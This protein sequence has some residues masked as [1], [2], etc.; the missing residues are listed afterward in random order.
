[1]GIGDLGNPAAMVPLRLEDR[2]KI[3]QQLIDEYKVKHGAMDVGVGLV[4]L[5][6]GAAIPA[7]VAAIAMQSPVIYQP[8]ARKLAQVYLASPGDLE[9]ATA[10]IVY[11]GAEWDIILSIGADF[12]GEFIQQIAL[13]MLA[14][15]GVGAAATLIPVIGAFVA[16]GLD[17]VIATKMT[18]RVG[19]MVSIY[20]QNGARW[21]GTQRDTYDVAKKLA[22]GLSEIRREIPEVRASLRRTIGPMIEMMRSGGMTNEQIRQALLGQGVPADLIEEA[23]HLS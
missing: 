10:N 6:P 21:H 23:L 22:G 11:P 5:I 14:D 18:K 8:L 13:D 1:M 16:A 15:V 12:G 20:F 7:L 9:K 2:N 4:G 3:A 17:Y 19:Q